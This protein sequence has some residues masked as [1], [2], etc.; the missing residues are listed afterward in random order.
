M[1]GAPWKGRRQ[2]EG[3]GM[4]G[5]DSPEDGRA[6]LGGSETGYGDNKRTTAREMSASG[7]GERALADDEN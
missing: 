2:D 3:T 7:R 5:V 6:Q 4:D 1:G